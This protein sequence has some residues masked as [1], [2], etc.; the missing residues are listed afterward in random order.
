MK[1]MCHLGFKASASR[2]L[3]TLN[4]FVDDV[5]LA[6]SNVSVDPSVQPS[7]PPFVSVIPSI[8]SS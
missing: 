3:S 1:A 8:A 4:G 2:L 5:I 7:T 6:S